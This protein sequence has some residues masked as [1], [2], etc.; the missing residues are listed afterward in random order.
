[1][2]LNEALAEVN[3]MLK[4]VVTATVLDATTAME[5]MGPAA[6]T[7]VEMGLLVASADIVAAD[8]VGCH[9]MGIDPMQ[10]RLIRF[11]AERGVGEMYLSRIAVVGERVE[12]HARRFRLPYEALAEDFPEVR[13][14]TEHAC[15]GC[16]L[17]LFRAMEIARHH[18]QAINCDTLVIGPG[19]TSEGEVLLV[20]QCT[21]AGWDGTPYVRGCPP[22]VEAI[23]EGMTGVATRED[24]PQS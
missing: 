23:R 3:R 1:M 10:A 6:A 11:C 8:S 4:P 21:K 24:V 19:V 12:D 14:V 20:G 18:G 7:P 22:R 17:N 2:E 9:L 16:M 15:S 5:G 13:L